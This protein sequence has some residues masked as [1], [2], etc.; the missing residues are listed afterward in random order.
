MAFASDFLFY[1]E[2]NLIG[3]Y[4]RKNGWVGKTQ[5]LSNS[6]GFEHY[7]KFSSDYGDYLTTDLQV[8][9]A[10]DA[11]QRFSDAVSCEIH[12][13]WAEYRVNNGLKIK[14]GH[15]EPAFGLEQVIDAHST[16]L[17]T[18]VMEDIG[19]TKDWGVELRGS[20][21]GFDYWVALQLGSGM[22][23]RRI[24]SS[25]LVSARVGTPAGREFQYGISA[26]CG[27][28]LDTEGMSTFPKNHLLSDKVILKERIG[29]DC[30]YNWNS[31]VLKG[32]TAFGVN[33]NS[34]VIGYLVETDYT[35]PRA[36]NWEFETQFQSFVNDLGSS[37]T[38]NST[39]SVG[40]SYKLSQAITLRA[41]FMHDLNQYHQER[42][43][44]FLVQFYYYG[45]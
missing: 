32:E 42:D 31:F 14:G 15:F 38:D 30:L 25:Y 3:G 10:Y 13:A 36:Q 22:S 9:G 2:L 29:F 41:A 40:L 37:R 7:A 45:K 20:L 16:I 43:T 35:P 27:N 12:N 24:D 18:L 4:S 21:S 11:N 23:I 28:V 33:D 44:E 17:Q 5:E 39:L 19:Y 1:K 8:R 6:A 26:L 34:N